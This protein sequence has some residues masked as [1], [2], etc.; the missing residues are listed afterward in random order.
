M[1]TAR[2]AK[3]PAGKIVVTYAPYRALPDDSRRYELLAGE[4]DMTPAPGTQHQ[5]SVMCLSA[6]LWCMSWQPIHIAWCLSTL[7]TPI[8]SRCYFRV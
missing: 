7:E 5:R 6:L 8:F 4:L 2:V 1:S 3:P